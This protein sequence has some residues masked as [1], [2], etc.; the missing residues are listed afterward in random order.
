MVEKIFNALK[1]EFSYLGL[2]DSVLRPYA[3]SL[4][5][6]G[7]VTD[8]NLN[9]VV[10][11]QKSSLEAIQK[12]NDKRAADAMKTAEEKAEAKRK[13]AEEAEAK[14]AEE[15]AKKAK[16]DEAK[17]A[18]EEKAVENKE[19]TPEW[20]KAY[21]TAQEE[22]FKEAL[23][24]NKA[25]EDSLKSLQDENAKFKTEQDAAK[26]NSFIAS[27]AKR[28][29]VPE[30]RSKE[31]FSISTDMD[32]K[33]ITEYLSQVANNVKA[34]MLPEEKMGFPKFDGKATKEEIDKIAD[35]LLK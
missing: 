3:E 33:A 28:L 21:Q 11:K 1:Q 29:G 23:E 27:E 19:E 30:W 8:D 5:A 4:G 17:K 35:N 14:K 15:A 2:G 20:F 32:E 6:C 26:R 24:K 22:K 13:A 31:G 7:F 25:L 9:D 12:A 34:N 10:S 18:A 16:E